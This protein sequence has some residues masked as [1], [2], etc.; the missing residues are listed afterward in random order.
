[1]NYFYLPNKIT[2]K[3]K[4]MFSKYYYIHIMCTKKKKNFTYLKQIFT[5]K[6]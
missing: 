1:M 4:E 3:L 2:E 5:F 6:L